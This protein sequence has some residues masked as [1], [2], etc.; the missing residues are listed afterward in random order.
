MIPLSQLKPLELLDVGMTEDS[1]LAL[2]TVVVVIT[3]E[4]V[5]P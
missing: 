1:L 4:L 3:L 5:K 2:E